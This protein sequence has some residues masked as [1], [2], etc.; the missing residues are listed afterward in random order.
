MKVPSWRL[1]QTELPSAWNIQLP[2]S[3]ASS[4]KWYSRIAFSRFGLVGVDIKSHQAQTAL[5]HPVIVQ[6]NQLQDEGCA[7]ARAHPRPPDIHKPTGGPFAYLV[8]QGRSVTSPARDFIRSAMRQ[9][10]LA[11]WASKPVQGL[12]AHVSQELFRPCLNPD[13][14]RHC[15]IP[16]RWRRW[17]LPQDDLRVD[18]APMF[19]RCLRAIGGSWTERLHSDADLQ[20]LGHRWIRCRGLDN[21]RTCPLCGRG[22]CTPRH[23]I[24]SCDHMSPL[25]DALRDAVEAALTD[26]KPSDFLIAAASEWRSQN[27]NLLPGAPSPRHSS[28]WPV[29]SAWRWLVAFPLS[30]RLSFPKS[31]GAA[32]GTTATEPK[33]MI[34]PTVGFSLSH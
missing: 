21:V 18:L 16:A 20:Q 34:L 33:V 10:A 26:L 28:R 13:L 5:P 30:G 8:C 31:P 11:S 22:P 17:A 3:E 32:R 15:H 6:G 7:K 4:S 29:L 1:Q 24:M 19:F 27:A 12:V 14:Y 2:G 9:E 25:V 23:V